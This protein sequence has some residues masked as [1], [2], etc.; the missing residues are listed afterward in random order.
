MALGSIRAGG[1]G[2]VPAAR[3]PIAAYTAMAQ[4]TPNIATPRRA[5]FCHLMSLLQD[6]RRAVGD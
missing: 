2:G 4:A 3:S 5:R 6:S 1:A